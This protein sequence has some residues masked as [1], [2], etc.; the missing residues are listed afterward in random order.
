MKKLLITIEFLFIVNFIFCQQI[1]NYSEQTILNIDRALYITGESIKFSVLVLN[2]VN[3]NEKLLSKI[4]YIEL[5]TSN[6]KQI[7]GKKYRIDNSKC[8]GTI[9]IPNNLNSG[10]YYIR[11][12]TK[13]M[14]NN[15]PSSYDYQYIKIINPYNKDILNGFNHSNETNNLKL[16]SLTDDHNNFDIEISKNIF[17]TRENVAIKV[18]N[19]L[20]DSLLNIIVTVTPEFTANYKRISSQETTNYSNIY[21]PETRGITL[22]GLLKDKT[23]NYP[24]SQKTIN[25]SILE[26]NKNVFYSVIT[27]LKGYFYFALPDL[28]GNK[29]IFISTE[30]LKN[31]TP[32]LLID[33][34]FCTNNIELPNPKF[35]LTKKERGIAY[36]LAINYKV[37]NH[38]SS[39]TSVKQYENYS[40][41][42]DSLPFY[43]KPTSTLYLDDYISLPTFED[44]FTEIP[45]LV[46]LKKSKGRKQ[47]K[48]IGNHPE[49]A[50][51]EP[52]VMVDL[53]PVNNIENI[54]EISPKNI[55]RIEVVT[56]PYIKGDV[57]YGGIINIVSI[58][59]DLAGIKLPESGIFL[60][61]L[62]LEEETSM[63]DSYN[64]PS[65]SN[66]PDSRNTLF[67]N[68]NLKFDINN[69]TNFSFTTSDI[70]GKYI[71]K[72]IGTTKN[73]E[74]KISTTKFEVK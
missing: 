66:I 22:T 20:V 23:T 32:E 41:Y 47:F 12:Y 21:I 64:I 19:K 63:N 34:D 54:L 36:K 10:N 29:D 39:D 3:Y 52:L 53:V 50:I 40:M 4:L 56:S 9:S 45:F 73:G 30:Y 69:S 48:I 46:R 43:G 61:Y 58:E 62:F 68:P 67:W 59:N 51:Y 2:N 11:A 38:F 6:G 5:I 60:N 27:N 31:I 57:T 18:S 15:G 44:Y 17:S 74:T 72:V 70:Q 24:L 7:I 65:L 26:D 1:S 25:L 71:I 42:S 49:L 14:R 37:H 13:F 16:V 55:S 28:H 33:N 35:S 8:S